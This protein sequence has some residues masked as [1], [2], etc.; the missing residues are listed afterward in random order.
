MS[1]HTASIHW[2]RDGRPFERD[3]Y[4]RAHEWRFDGGQ[5][6][7]ASAAP[8]YLG[9]E[10]GVDPEEA[11]VAALSSCRMLTV[12]AIAAKKRWTGRLAVTRVVLRPRIAFAGGPP[13]A[14]ALGRL[15]E[16]AHAHCFIAN[17]V[18]CQIAIEPR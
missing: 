2:Q 16:Q 17:S 18:R 1:E 13:D 12:L 11:L 5:R 3:R 9:S 8:A 6:I 7:A 14:Q 15:H 4:S 10:S